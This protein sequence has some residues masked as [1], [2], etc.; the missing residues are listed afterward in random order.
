[1]LVGITVLVFAWTSRIV[2]QVG[3]FKKCVNRIE[4]EARHTTLVPPA[5]HVEHRLLYG[6]IAPIQVRLFGIEK[7]VVPLIGRAIELPCR[8][9]ERGSPVIRRL[10]RAFAVAPHVPIAVG[11][12][13]G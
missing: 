4:T 1:L 2:A 8:P 7:M 10:V 3:I 13:F 6:G 9:A 12:S 11:G 5:R